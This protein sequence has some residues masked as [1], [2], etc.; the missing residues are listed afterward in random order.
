MPGRA[1]MTSIS[2]VKSDMS[3]IK[4]GGTSGVSGSEVSAIVAQAATEQMEKVI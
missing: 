1:G 4:A 2:A 3:S